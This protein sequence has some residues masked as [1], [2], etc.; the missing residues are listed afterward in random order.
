MGR[1]PAEVRRR[2]LPKYCSEYADRHG[3]VRVR[4]RRK[5]QRTHYFK[6]VAWTA[7]FMVE[8]QACLAGVEAPRLTPGADRVRAGTISALIVAYYGSPKYTGLAASTRANYRSILE[9]FRANHGDKPVLAIERRHIEAIIG[10]MA[11]TPS[12]ANNLLDKLRIIM[13]HAVAL[14]MRRDDPTVGIKGFELNSDGFHTWTEEDIAQFERHH[15]PGSR[16]RRALALLLYTG[17]RRS[18]VVGMGRQ[19]RTPGGRLR[20]RQ[21]KT[22]KLLELP[23]HPALAEELDAVPA[24]Q[25]TYL[26]TGQNRPFTAN[27]FGNWFRQQCDAAGLR[28]CS[29]HGLRKAAARRLAEAGCSNQEIKAITGHSSDAEVAHYTAAVDQRR[30]ADQALRRLT[31]GTKGEPEKANPAKG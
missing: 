22:G 6:A 12:A 13:A 4:F 28:H 17:Q 10:S 29:A 9:R 30:M 25:M 27:G 2:R 16:A 23:V 19:H 15:P 20:V 11:A 5:G 18:D 1:S 24:G 31:D 7:E 14:D 3:K 8:Y 21:Q 26:E